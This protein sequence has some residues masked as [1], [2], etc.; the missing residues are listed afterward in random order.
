MRFQ[1]LE[2]ASR[3]DRQ[4]RPVN[5]SGLRV[6]ACGAENSVFFRNEIPSPC[7]VP[8]STPDPRLPMNLGLCSSVRRALPA[9]VAGLL[10]LAPLQAQVRKMHTR[11]Y[12]RLSQ[13]QID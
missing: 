6:L 12:T 13:L 3:N 7:R 8:F 2:P 4:I 5:A 9:L 10:A 11:D 1:R